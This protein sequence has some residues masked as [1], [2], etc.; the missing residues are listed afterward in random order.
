MGDVAL[1]IIGLLISLQRDS[2]ERAEESKRQLSKAYEQ[3]QNLN[4]SKDQFIQN[5][6][7]ELR[8][9]L[10]ALSG[11][12][13]L[14]LE[15]NEY[16]DRETRAG[17][18]QNAMLSCEE[19]QQLVNNILDSLQ[20]GSN[21]TP[22]ELKAIPLNEFVK[23]IIQRANPHWRLEQRIYVDIP[24]PLSVQAHQQ[25][26]RQVLT[27]LI[28]NAIKYTPDEQLIFIAA[29][30]INDPAR[31]E[32][33]ICIRV[34][35]FGPGIP[36]QETERIFEQ[37]TRLQRDTLGQVRGTGLGLSISKQ[38]VEK[39]GGRIWVESAGLPGMGS[40]FN[41][42]LL[43]DAAEENTTNTELSDAQ[44]T[45]LPASSDPAKTASGTQ[46]LLPLV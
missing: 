7:H 21:E 35:D 4:R 23:N 25:F 14:L 3:M 28:S 2:F 17:F 27:N 41:F 37:F 6:N 8:T 45:D 46:P 44:L 20:I 24:R 22:I 38:L 30:P 33:E 34:K 26:L 11:C 12:I 40:C 19:L 32:P 10:T 31:T 39:M 9:P 29:R 36:P 5:V 13:E 15:Q 1:L 43:A 18:L 16:F 42:T